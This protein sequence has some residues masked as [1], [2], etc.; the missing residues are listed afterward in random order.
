MILLSALFRALRVVGQIVARG[1]ASEE[2]FLYSY[3]ALYNV[4]AGDN[5]SVGTDDHA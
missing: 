4:S 2:H 3:C 1:R 5:V